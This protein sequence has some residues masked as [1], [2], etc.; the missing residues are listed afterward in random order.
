[1]AGEGDAV[2]AI[3]RRR[4]DPTQLLQIL[5]EAQEALGWISAETARHRLQP[6][7]ADNP[8]RERRAILFV[9]P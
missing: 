6:W 4:A 8:C 1:M 9:S 7:R 5:R 3:L 2:T